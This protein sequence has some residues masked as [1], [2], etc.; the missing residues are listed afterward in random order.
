M[1]AKVRHVWIL[2][3]HSCMQGNCCWGWWLLILWG[4]LVCSLHIACSWTERT[5][6][7]HWGWSGSSWQTG[8]WRLS[9]KWHRSWKG[10]Y[11]RL[12]HRCHGSWWTLLRAHT[13]LGW[14]VGMET[15]SQYLIY[16]EPTITWNRSGRD[17]NQLTISA[18]LLF[19]WPSA[20]ETT[21]ATG[22]CQ[23]H[24]CWAISTALYDL[25]LRNLGTSICSLSCIVGTIVRV[26]RYQ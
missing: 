16:W 15:W 2:S 14:R 3:R 26:R 1:G 17:L 12:G 9:E 4:L 11:S 19:S 13:L 18:Y 24:V 25:M 7:F 6:D 10:G 23:R 8:S 21:E 22:S 5:G 20:V